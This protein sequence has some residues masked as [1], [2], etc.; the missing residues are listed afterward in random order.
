LQRN[1]ARP[2]RARIPE[3]GLRA[4]LARLLRPRVR[5]GFDEVFAAEFDGS[6]GFIVRPAGEESGPFKRGGGFGVA[7]GPRL[8][9]RTHTDSPGPTCLAAPR[10]TTS[11][12]WA[13]ALGTS[14]GIATT[15]PGRASAVRAYFAVASRYLAMIPAGT[16]PRSLTSIP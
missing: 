7:M 8:R 14:G 5:D 6:A 2:V 3:L 15:R 13:R 10:A 9:R 4:T 12:I 16:R 11:T 1:A